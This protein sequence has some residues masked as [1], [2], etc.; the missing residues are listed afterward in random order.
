VKKRNNLVSTVQ[1]NNNEL[2]KAYKNK[3]TKFTHKD[4]EALAKKTDLEVRQV[5][6]WLRRRTAS[7]KPSTLA[8]FSECG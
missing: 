4:M 1:P 6:R 7:D 3:K 5:E 2:E 8:K